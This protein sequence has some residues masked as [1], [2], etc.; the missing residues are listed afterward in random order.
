MNNTINFEEFEVLQGEYNAI[1][2]DV[3]AISNMELSKEAKQL[4]LEELRLQKESV[5]TRMHEFVNSL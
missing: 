1:Q 3:C 4:P 2:R 5:K